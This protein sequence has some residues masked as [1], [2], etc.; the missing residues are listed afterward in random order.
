M[1]RSSRTC[2]GLGV[3]ETPNLTRDVM[4]IRS[5]TDWGSH[6]PQIRLK[7]AGPESRGGLGVPPGEASP[8][9]PCPDASFPS[10]VMEPMQS[11]KSLPIH[12]LEHRWPDSC[13]PVPC[14]TRLQGQSLER[15]QPASMPG[16]PSNKLRSGVHGGRWKPKYELRKLSPARLPP[17]R[18]EVRFPRFGGHPTGPA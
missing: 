13:L 8:A 4:R 10:R 9:S 12:D 3:P 14:M 5:G 17:Q 2:G 18:W 15:E 6:T 11:D 1:S 7:S 16:N